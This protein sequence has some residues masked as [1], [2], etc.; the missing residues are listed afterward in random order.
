MI[1]AAAI[2]AILSVGCS[3]T[4]S[5]WGHAAAAGAVDELTGD[6]GAAKL[7]ELSAEVA[8]AAAASAREEILGDASDALVAK[9]VASAG[10]QARAELEAILTERLQAR[11]RQTLRLEIDEA[12]GATTRGELAA[13]REEVAGTPLQADMDALIDAAAPHLAQA[14][15]QA[16][17]GAVITLQSEVEKA[18]VESEL[19]AKQWRPIAIGF[20]VGSGLLLVVLVLAMAAIRGHQK[21]IAA[22]VRG[23]TG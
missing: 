13:L 22:L 20:A 23:K 7:A 14:V 17:A 1:R 12:L 16:V 8:G 5:S 18:K 11:I 10:A 9:L 19:E 6:A 21:T 2:A 15:Q 3:P 4:F